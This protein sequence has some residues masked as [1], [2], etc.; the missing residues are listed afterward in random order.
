MAERAG[1]RKRVADTVELWRFSREKGLPF[2]GRLILAATYLREGAAGFSL[3]NMRPGDRWWGRR[4]SA[5]GT[6]MPP[7]KDNPQRGP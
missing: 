5:Q 7:N 1:V 4:G 3:I 6:T 2:W